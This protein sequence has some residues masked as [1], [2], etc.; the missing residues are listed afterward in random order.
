MRKL[1]SFTVDEDVI[2]KLKDHTIKTD[3]PASRLIERLLK[4]FF[5]NKKKKVG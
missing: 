2:K 1:I 3:I 4:E 5:K